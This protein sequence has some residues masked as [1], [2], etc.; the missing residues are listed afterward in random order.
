[1]H[2]ACIGIKM[3]NFAEFITLIATRKLNNTSGLKVLE[4]MLEAGD[5]PIHIME[6]KELGQMSNEGELAE[7]VISVL[8]SHPA[9]LARYK[10]GEEQLL[11]FFIGMIMKE[12]QGTAD[13][14]IAKNILKVELNK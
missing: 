9:E 7:I 12:S 6:D 11:Q 5:S 4:E 10:A 2:L 8:E 13:P 1:M 3:I 14:G